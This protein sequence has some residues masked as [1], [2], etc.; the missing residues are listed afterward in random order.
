MLKLRWKYLRAVFREPGGTSRGVLREKPSWILNISNPD[1]GKQGWGEISI[2]PGLSPETEED[3]PVRLQWLA[4]NLHL[5]E[6]TLM[7]ELTPWPAIRFGVEMALRGL[8]QS[9]PLHWFD[10]PFYRGEK[11]I[12]TNGLIWMGDLRVM[13]KRIREKVA[14][15]FHCLKLKIGALSWADE[16]A[17]L[18]SIHREKDS[19]LTIRVDANGAFSPEEAPAKLDQLAELGIHSIEQPLPAGMWDE[20]GRLA[21]TTPVPIALDEE[22]IGIHSRLKKQDLL[23]TIRP[24]YLILKPSLTGGWAS[25]DEWIDLAQPLGIDWWATSAL[26]LNLG[27]S[28]IAQWVAIHDNPLPQGLGTGKVFTDNIQSPLYLDGEWLYNNSDESWQLPML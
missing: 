25:C 17:L 19:G 15:G 20:M 21:E 26:E 28:A 12:C 7:H 23:N 24:Q 9:N 22:L 27:L 2:I 16:Y 3:I 4:Q 14:A 5:P 18:Q 13:Q 11:G 1:T 8:Q 10:T 6:Q